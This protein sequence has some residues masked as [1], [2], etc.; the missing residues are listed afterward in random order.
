[1]S[2]FY[3]PQNAVKNGFIDVSGKEA[4]HIVRV[5]RLCVGDKITTFDGTGREYSGIIRG[6]RPKSISIEITGSRDSPPDKLFRIILIQAIPKKEKMDFIIE[7]STELGVSRIVP[8]F[9]KRTI[10][11]WDSV[12]KGHHLER[13]L[14]IAKEAAKQCGRTDIPAIDGTVGIGEAIRGLRG[15]DLA[16]MATLSDGAVSI[17]KIFE[18][19]N[20]G[21][22]AV[23]IGPEGDFTVDEIREAA[24]ADF[25]MVSLGPRVLKSDTAGLAALAMIDYEFSNRM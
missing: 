11:V 7:K 5:M 17:R 24:E 12:K 2:R 3:V 25:K 16:V 22:I 8:V 9:S 13:W 18:D 15:I 6:I 14:S 19:F 20:G 10:P 1:M 21:D 4:H 23:A